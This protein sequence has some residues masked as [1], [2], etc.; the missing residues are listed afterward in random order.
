M[1]PIAMNQTGRVLPGP[2]LT[3]S[4]GWIAGFGQ[5]GGALLPFITGALAGSAG[6]TTLQPLYV[7]PNTTVPSN[8]Y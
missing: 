6:I 5:A 1:Y 2:L 4:I 7:Q 3:A 8:P